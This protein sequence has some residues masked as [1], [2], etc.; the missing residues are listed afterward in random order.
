MPA[1][2]ST[3][4]R[5]PL[6]ADDPWPQRPLRCSRRC[7]TRPGAGD[8]SGPQTFL[9]AETPWWDASQLY[10]GGTAGTDKLPRRSGADGKLL[11]G[12]GNRLV[13]PDDPALSP[14]F[15]PGWWLGLAMMSTLFIREHNAIADALKAGVPAPGPT[16]TCTS[17]PGWSSPR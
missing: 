10:G 6:A 7:P 11:I 8:D 15:V 2:R 4:S 9:N 14:A 12:P 3:A 13:L 5:L 16:R 17:G 1:T